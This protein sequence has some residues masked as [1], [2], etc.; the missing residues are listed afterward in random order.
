MH[1]LISFNFSYQQMECPWKILNKEI[2]CKNVAVSGPSLD[3]IRRGAVYFN[4]SSRGKV[5]MPKV[6]KEATIKKR[7]Q[8]LFSWLLPTRRTS[9][10]SSGSLFARNLKTLRR[11]N[12]NLN[13]WNFW[14][15]LQTP[16]VITI[17]Q[18]RLETI[19]SKIY[20]FLDPKE[21]RECQLVVK[22]IEQSHPTTFPHH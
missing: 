19:L 5:K 21:V 4:W 8:K 17:I 7:D 20:N 15:V 18:F 22:M 1:I 6:T 13:W 11:P 2:S 12:W 10:Q 3:D 9:T 16:L 14:T